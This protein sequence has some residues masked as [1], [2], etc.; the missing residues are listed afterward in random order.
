MY[1]NAVSS[2]EEYIDWEAHRAARER[3][4][5]LLGIDL[6]EQKF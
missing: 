1:S 5:E 4:K 3:A 2:A 6:D